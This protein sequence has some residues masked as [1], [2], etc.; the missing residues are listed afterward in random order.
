MMNLLI[1]GKKRK[2]K[3][4]NNNSSITV[5]IIY[6]IHTDT[7]INHLAW[8]KFAN[9]KTQATVTLRMFHYIVLHIIDEG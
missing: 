1:S 2:K 3:E 6:V 7:V 9:K 5:E 8:Q 4:S